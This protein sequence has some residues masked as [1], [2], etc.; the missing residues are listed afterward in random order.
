MQQQRA[1]S[2]PA[3]WRRRFRARHHMTAAP[4][5]WWS[6]APIRPRASPSIPEPPGPPPWRSIRFATWPQD[7]W[8]KYLSCR[9][10]LPDNLLPALFL[11]RGNT[12]RQKRTAVL[13]SAPY[14][15]YEF[16]NYEF[17]RPL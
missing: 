16:L 1:R 10:R 17:L 14:N 7:R 11:R 15:N 4:R 9:I 13:A 2:A 3:E 12:I 6:T 8:P 5:R